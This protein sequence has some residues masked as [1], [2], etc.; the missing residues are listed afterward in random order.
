V[1]ASGMSTT[2]AV[3]APERIRPWTMV[4]G[5]ALT[6]AMCAGLPWLARLTS[7]ASGIPLA[8]LG[9]Y[10]PMLPLL[11][12]LVLALTRSFRVR[13]VLVIGAMLLVGAGINGSLSGS[14]RS[15]IYA[16]EGL[17]GDTATRALA[18]AV[19][20]QLAG[21]ARTQDPT[22]PIDRLYAGA[23]R[24]DSDLAD[25]PLE[26]W[27]PPAGWL[28]IFAGLGIVLTMSLMATTSRQWSQHERLPHP[29]LQIPV[30]IATRS[31]FADRGFRIAAAVI[32]TYWVYNLSGTNGLHH[33][34][35]IPNS[36]HIPDLH[37]LAGVQSDLATG[38]VYD[39]QWARLRF[40]PIAVGIAFFLT[41]EMGFSVWSGF[42]LGALLCG[43]IYAAGVPISIESQGRV[44]GAGAA[45]A[46]AG[47]ILFIGRHH[48]GA[49]VKGAFGWGDAGGDRAGIW[50]CRL[51][52]ASAAAIAGLLGWLTGSF[53]A[54]GVGVLLALAYLVVTARVVAESGLPYF[55]ISHE[56]G[57]V[58]N[59]LGLPMVLPSATLICLI[60]FGMVFM[61]NSAQHIAAFSA[62]GAGLA[63]HHRVPVGRLLIGLGALAMV[64]LVLAL[65]SEV[66]SQWTGGGGEPL[67]AP[68]RLGDASIIAQNGINHADGP[69]AAFVSAIFS[70]PALWGAVA[71][72]ALFA[73][74]RAWPGFAF[75]PLGLVVATSFP[76][77]SVW[78]SLL[79]GWAAKVLILRYGGP[80]LYGRLKPVAIGLVVGDLL[81]FAIQYLCVLGAGLGQTT[82]QPWLPPGA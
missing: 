64:G 7:A 61:G 46:M 52:L 78:F 35:L 73:I 41:L 59:S 15:A 11:V 9:S 19:P 71:L 17:S 77:W 1:A 58:T 18:A 23:Q 36:L 32:L 56:I 6:L 20:E 70:S 26:I 34:P 40:R 57:M 33:L 68:W 50:G 5:A 49:L 16:R 25:F 53:T 81:G 74:R 3:A 43:W 76:V 4:L 69:N 39:D 21:P 45:I 63:E 13:E 22:H 24:G 48:Y 42:W 12:M 14:V 60:W 27:A 82:L 54:A 28:L 2:G 30:A 38:Y 66:A 65:G 75:H 79:L 10:L 47:V 72:F 55:Q 37:K 67:R 8:P 62:Q 44:F 80:Q 31:I 29:T 51:L